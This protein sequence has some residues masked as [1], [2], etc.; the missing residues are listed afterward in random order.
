MAGFLLTAALL[1]PK[2]IKII[3]ELGVVRNSVGADSFVS[4]I[5]RREA[6]SKPKK[7]KLL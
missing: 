5:C 6:L 2:N 3:A 4:G 1:K 7:M